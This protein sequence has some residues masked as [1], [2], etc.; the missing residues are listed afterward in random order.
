M[1]GEKKTEKKYE[2]IKKKKSKILSR[3]EALSY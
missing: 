3:E 2:S 1:E